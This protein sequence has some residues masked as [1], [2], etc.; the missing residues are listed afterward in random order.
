[1]LLL[2]ITEINKQL[3]SAVV[4]GTFLALWTILASSTPQENRFI[5]QAE[6]EY[7]DVATTASGNRKVSSRSSYQ[8]CCASFSMKSIKF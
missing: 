5:S 3:I 6:K 2:Y 4:L 1:M 8:I 7:L